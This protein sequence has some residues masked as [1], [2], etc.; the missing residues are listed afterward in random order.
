MS[1]A[2]QELD[3]TIAELTAP[4]KGILAA[5][6][7]ASTIERRFNSV[8]VPCTQESRRDY[9][10]MLFRHPVWRFCRRRD[11]VRGNP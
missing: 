3:R 10:E 2:T 1:R 11:S 5:D 9:G 6:E 7:S 4:G 8:D